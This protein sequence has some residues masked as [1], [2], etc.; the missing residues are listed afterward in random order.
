MLVQIVELNG[1]FLKY[2]LWV[3]PEN[4]LNTYRLFFWFFLGLPGED[5]S[6]WLVLI[7]E[8][9]HSFGVL[10]CSILWLNSAA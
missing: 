10:L 8:R 5:G 3:P 4:L 6:E 9:L 1:F 7:H 2:V